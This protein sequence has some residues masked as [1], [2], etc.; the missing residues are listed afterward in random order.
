MNAPLANALQDCLEA[1]ESG[2]AFE[3]ALA[4]HPELEAELRPL[5]TAARLV[6]RRRP[7]PS[8]AFRAQ[9]QVAL[10]QPPAADGTASGGGAFAPGDW[11]AW[12]RPFVARL[13]GSA[14]AVGLLLGG[15]VLASANS[16]PGDLLYAVRRGAERIREVTAQA[17]APV[18]TGVHLLVAP[19]QPP[20]T[21]DTAVAA[22][23]ASATV[24]TRGQADRRQATPRPAVGPVAR[25]DAAADGSDDR[26]ASPRTAGAAMPP[27]AGEESAP[28]DGDTDGGAP[29][30]PGA[31]PDAGTAGPPAP[32][33][34]RPPG[35]PGRHGRGGDRRGAGPTPGT[36][37]PA[38]RGG[39]GGPLAPPPEPPG[40]PA[41]PDDP[42]APTLTAQVIGTVEPVPIG[43][44]R[45]ATIRGAVTR[46][47]GSPEGS[48][49]DR[50]LVGAY[51]LGPNDEFLWWRR[52]EARASAAGL[53][54]IGGLPPGRYKVFAS[55]GYGY[56]W[57]GRWY[58]GSAKSAD[59]EVLELTPGETLEAIDIRFDR[60]PPW[61]WLVP[62]GW[63]PGG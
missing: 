43:S 52:W 7:R 55:T 16:R 21:A 1:I 33:W 41:A 48:P 27:A 47:N 10:A 5:L 18:A 38:E 8:P 14:V 59:A 54:Q 58:P 53:Y 57:Q 30:T 13:A 24:D 49:I 29:G 50:A 42:A 62:T 51:L 44:G 60:L 36:R 12:W 39:R 11:R 56:R 22:T 34:A 61:L 35:E 3:R 17:W 46:D 6:R 19:P 23:T 31:P 15:T 32:P 45:L 25:A 28:G 63:L 20:A 4:R 40:T 9:C 2:V 26:P 37:Q